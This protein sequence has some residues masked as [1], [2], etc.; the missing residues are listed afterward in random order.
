MNLG[1][2]FLAWATGEL[3]AHLRGHTFSSA[4]GS[5]DWLSLHIGNEVLY[6]H[7]APPMSLALLT[8]SQ[9]KSYLSVQTNSSF[10]QSLS[11]KLSGSRIESVTRQEGD[12]VLHIDLKKFIGGGKSELYRLVIEATSRL[13][14]CLLIDEVGRVL[15]AA[16]HRSDEY[17]SS[18]PGSLYAPPPP[19]DTIALTRTMSDEALLEALPKARDVSPKLAQALREC[20]QTQ[21][22]NLREALFGD[23]KVQQLG[24]TITV[25]GTLLPGAREIKLPALQ[26][27]A[28]AVLENLATQAQKA[29][30]Q[31]AL[32]LL[33]RA[34]KRLSG[35]R[36]ELQ[37]W[38]KE[39]AK[40]PL[41]KSYGDALIQNPQPLPS[42]PCV[43][44][45]YWT[46]QGQERISVPIK[47]GLSPSA[48][49]KRYYDLYHKL[50]HES[51]ETITKLRELDEEINDIDN[52]VKI[53]RSASRPVDIKRIS[54]QVE[55]SYGI[56]ARHKKAKPQLP[57]HLRYSYKDH[58]F[59]VGLNAQANR[60]VT[61]K[62]ASPRDFWFHV[63]DLPGS[64]VI[65]KPGTSD[66]ELAKEIAASLAL[67][68]SKAMGTAS[69][70][71]CEKRHVKPMRNAGPGDVIFQFP[72]TFAPTPIFWQDY[73]K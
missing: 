37:R 32:R 43:D 58:T 7:F 18:L 31:N 48:L 11:A 15:D 10:A 69:V 51:G 39:R 68:Y 12:R 5:K 64:H 17:R 16:I 27:L 13:A 52:L 42:T 71:C 67:Y 50:T 62:V 65:L 60:Y 49:A 3:A 56:T 66:I 6:F 57:P 26:S 19:M 14:N 45:S 35:H 24:E 28:P 53:L 44:L 4:T 38:Q 40:A 41:Y 20:V 55:A 1:T 8:P 63:H 33:E 21:A 25:A 34:R 54:S 61:F 46:E 2:E 72:E 29:L 73:L 47:P 22:C 9:A 70:D 30:A 36:A 23:K 59:I